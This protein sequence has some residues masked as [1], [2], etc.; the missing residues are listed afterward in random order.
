M[1]PKNPTTSLQ[2]APS[3]PPCTACGGLSI[4]YYVSVGV[5]AIPPA[6]PTAIA[7]PPTG[8]PTPRPTQPDVF[9]KCEFC[10]KLIDQYEIS[11]ARLYLWD[12]FIRGT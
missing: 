12:P 10:Y 7:K 6:A 8:S 5:K 3:R 11:L 9:A 4:G 1:P 2:A